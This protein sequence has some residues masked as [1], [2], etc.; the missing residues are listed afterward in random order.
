MNH[1]LIL[2]TLKKVLKKKGI[3]Y[4]DLSREL[5]LSESGIKKLLT[6]KDISLKRLN[7]VSEAAGLELLD[8]LKLVSEQEVKSIQLTRK[9]EETLH[10]QPALFRVFWFLTVEEKSPNEIRK[11]EKLTEMQL[12]KFLLRLENLDLIK[13]NR[14]GEIISTHKG[15]YRWSGDHVL[16]N[17]LHR[18]WSQN[19][20]KKVLKDKENPKKRDQQLYRLSYLQLTASSRAEFFKRLQEL[21][22]DFARRSQREKIELNS[23]QLIPISLLFALD[24]SGFLDPI[25]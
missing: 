11:N 24:S 18:E 14:K 21:T 2:E 19:T 6:A 23:N 5:G 3:Q 20:L 16:L 7:Q 25:E 1:D 22:D 13:R 17:K 10:D 4:K 8:V 9:Q 12:E 15:L